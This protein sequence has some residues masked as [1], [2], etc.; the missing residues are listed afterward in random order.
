MNKKISSGQAMT[1]EIGLIV[2]MFFPGISNILIL[3]HAKNSSFISSLIGSFLGLIFL[4]IIILIS[5]KINDQNLKCYLKEK[6]GF[7]GIFLNIIL[8]LIAIFILFINSWLII[9]FIISQFLT[10][11][12]YYFI[13]FVLFSIIAFVVNKGIETMSR[14]TFILFIITIVFVIILWIALIPYVKLDNLKP[15]I[16]ATFDNNIKSSL[17][18]SFSSSL[19]IVYVLDLKH[20]TI[21]KENFEKKLV[22]GYI[23]SITIIILSIFFITTIITIP[24]AKILTYPIYFLYKKIQ[25]FGFIER[26]ENFATIQILVAFYIQA[27]FLI[28][29]LRK[30]IKKSSNILTYIISLVIP[31]ISII[32]FKNFNIIKL[33]RSTP[34]IV[35]ILLLVILILFFRSLFIKNK[36]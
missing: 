29:Y 16:D 30:N 27:S 31:L 23:I 15:F 25:M 8:I 13:A 3:D 18:F 19:P 34:Y 9:D 28:Y 17:I 14:T 33:L 5:K 22:I 10:R 35:S 4:F 21:D 6:L 32:I 7:L 24:V 36:K 1:V 11:T 12:S 2:A 26:I 20:I